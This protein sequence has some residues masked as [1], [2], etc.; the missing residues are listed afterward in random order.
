MNGQWP[1]LAHWLGGASVADPEREHAL[2]MALIVRPPDIDV[3]PLLFAELTALSGSAGESAAAARFLA[4]F[5]RLM[6]PTWLGMRMH[7][8]L[9]RESAR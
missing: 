7:D 8:R 2:K 6:G 1:L 4:E 3:G 9:R 5:E